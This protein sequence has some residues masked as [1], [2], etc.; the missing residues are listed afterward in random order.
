MAAGRRS[1]A[2]A[3]AKRMGDVV[4]SYVEVGRPEKTE[5]LRVTGLDES[6]TR[7][8]VVEA[9]AKKR[10]C[11]TSEVTAGALQPGQAWG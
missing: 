7:E 11:P 8:E 1:K 6:I 5:E 9:V 2:D 10:G 4:G 3:L